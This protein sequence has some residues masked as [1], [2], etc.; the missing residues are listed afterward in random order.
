MC[1]SSTEFNLF[2]SGG[3]GDP[4]A[5]A[6][7]ESS[8]NIDFTGSAAACDTPITSTQWYFY[9]D[10]DH[11]TDECDADAFDGATDL[12]YFSIER[13]DMTV[14]SSFSFTFD[15]SSAP[16]MSAFGFSGLVFGMSG[17]SLNYVE[18]PPM[19]YQFTEYYQSSGITDT[20]S[21]V[22]GSNTYYLFDGA[23]VY[24]HSQYPGGVGQ[25]QS[26][27]LS[28]QNVRFVEHGSNVGI[29]VA[30]SGGDGNGTAQVNMC[31]TDLGLCYNMRL[32]END[33]SYEGHSISKNEAKIDIMTTDGISYDPAE[34]SVGLR[35][36]AVA[37]TFEETVSNIDTGDTTGEAVETFG[38]GYFK[39]ATSALVSSTQITSAS[40]PGTTTVP[41]VKNTQA[42]SSDTCGYT[43]TSWYN[44]E[45]T[46][47]ETGTT[48]SNAAEFFRGHGFGD[49]ECMFFSMQINDN[50]KT[51]IF[52]DPTT[53]IDADA[54]STVVTASS[55]SSSSDSDSDSISTTVIV[56]IAVVGVVVA[57]VVV[58]AF[59]YVMRARK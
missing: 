26:S 28:F 50:T 51:Q 9:N 33:F 6:G 30:I 48:Y 45:A 43:S 14:D 46:D 16:S 13:H 8:L 36:V 58:G 17:P 42:M 53:G 19:P 35:I 44:A 49:L 20:S 25:T 34:D 2:F 57:V 40:Q 24:Q 10:E 11:T 22:F 1:L 38:A 41:V 15:G 54:A 5:D 39:T 7:C 37:M 52:W 4:A 23:F 18:G 21:K 27:T 29:S 55:S 32:S 31:D 59:I 3:S 12:T 47:S 56:A